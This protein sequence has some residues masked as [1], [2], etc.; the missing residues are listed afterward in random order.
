[1]DAET[2]AE[3]LRD[4]AEHHHAFE[5][6]APAHDWSDW[7]APYVLARLDGR[8]PEEATAAAGLRVAEVAHPAAE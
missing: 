2:L 7:Y 4:A 5:A 1:V 3:L 6:A 8:T